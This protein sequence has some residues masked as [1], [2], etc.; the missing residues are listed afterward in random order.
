MTLLSLIPLC[1]ALVGLGILAQHVA[2]YLWDPKRLRKYPG[3]NFFCGITN[4]AYIFELWRGDRFR[5]RAIAQAHEK[6]KVIRLGP[7]ALSFADVGAINDIYGHSTSC[8]KGD[9]YSTTAGS[10]RSLLDSVD[11]Q[12]HG[13][14]RKR[15]AA[16]FATKHLEGWE[17]KVVDKCA[18]MIAQFDRHCAALGKGAAADGDLL[19]CRKWFN[20]FTVEAIA[21]IAL[22]D[23]LGLIEAGNDT[24]TARNEHGETRNVSFVQSLH[25]IGRMAAPIVWSTSAYP[26][27]KTGL[28]LFSKSYEREVRNNSTYDDIIRQMVWKRKQ[29]QDSGERLDDLFACLVEDR[30]GGPTDLEVEEIAA[31]VNVFSKLFSLATT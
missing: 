25:G 13:V 31:E 16:A 23:H 17:H 28:S 6:H 9:M 27:L 10:H 1:L 24:V 22:S 26:L 3:L 7:N 19:D 18:K 20:L 8:L 4:L 14:K 15:L 30:N 29:R 12:E 5:T 21:D 11:R 2:I